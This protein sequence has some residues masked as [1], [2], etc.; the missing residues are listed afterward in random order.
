MNGPT[1]NPA[2]QF[3]AHAWSIIAAL[4]L[5]SA[6]FAQTTP[7]PPAES[8]A[9]PP[10]AKVAPTPPLLGNILAGVLIF[11]AVLTASLLPSKRGHQD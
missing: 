2:S 7:A 11:G 6:S 9:R 4:C 8:A 3:R 1:A 10:T 5:C